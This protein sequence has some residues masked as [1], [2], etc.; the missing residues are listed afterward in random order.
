MLSLIAVIGM[1]TVGVVLWQAVGLS[2]LSSV[3][4]QVDDAKPILSGVRFLLIGLLA[5]SWAKLPVFWGFT[6]H[7][8]GSTYDQWIALR[9]RVIGWLLVIE[10]VLGQNIPGQL[11]ATISGDST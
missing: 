6:D 5:I 3:S 4:D 11:Y 7:E 10:L 8:H 1:I 2:S 9:W